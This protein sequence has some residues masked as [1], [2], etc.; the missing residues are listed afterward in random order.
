M[1]D[2][3]SATEV[4]VNTTSSQIR[5]HYFDCCNERSTKHTL[6]EIQY[7]NVAIEATP[8]SGIKR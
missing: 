8:S 2:I 3:V 5:N 7:C 4:I 1:E 6:A